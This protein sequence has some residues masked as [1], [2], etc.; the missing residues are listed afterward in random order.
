M[1]YGLEFLMV[2]DSRGRHRDRFTTGS[3]NKDTWRFAIKRKI[4]A[5]VFDTEEGAVGSA[6]LTPPPKY[7]PPDKT[8]QKVAS[9]IILHTSSSEQESP[10]TSQSPNE[11]YSNYDLKTLHRKEDKSR[12]K[13]ISIKVPKGMYDK[14]LITMV[15]AFMIFNKSSIFH[16][17]VIIFFQIQIYGRRMIL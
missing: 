16:A 3:S 7:T 8:S 15:Y 14:F 9:T 2:Q 4:N 17:F 6:T 10:T 5:P 13:H 11:F 12:T 1:M